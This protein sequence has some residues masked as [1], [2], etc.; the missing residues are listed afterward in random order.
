MLPPPPQRSR[1]GTHC[2]RTG[3]I[4]TRNR[5]RGEGLPSQASRCQCSQAWRPRATCPQSGRATC[6]TR[7]SRQRRW[8]HPRGTQASTDARA[9]AARGTHSRQE[10]RN[11]TT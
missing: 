1:Q 7:T 3:S 5:S 6:E 10:L 2:A 11:R 8:S 4:G 9:A